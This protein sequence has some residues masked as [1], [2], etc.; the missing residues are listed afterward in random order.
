MNIITLI[1]TLYISIQNILSY[2]TGGTF[3]LGCGKP[4]LALPICENCR[5]LITK[6]KS[7]SFE[8]KE[9]CRQCGKILIAEDGLCS[10]CR[11]NTEIRSTLSYFPLHTYRLWK[12][13]LM[14]YWKSKD[15]RS[16]SLFFADLIYKAILQVSK[17]RNLQFD[18][19]V[20]VP[21]RPGKLKKKG[22]D[23][24]DELCRILHFKYKINIE[25]LLE[26]YDSH[27]Q[28]KL[29]KDQRKDK[30]GAE[31]GLKGD[32]KGTSKRVLILDDVI[33]T[34]STMEKCAVLLKKCGIREVYGMSLFIVD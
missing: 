28:K 1:E 13:D 6:I 24:I 17:E 25:H 18:S 29:S 11:E 22:W 4:C 15:V 19:I 12:K 20:P 34:G 30:N 10:Q 33:T 16:F 7:F 5:K 21:P 8:S 9:R 32:Y 23:Q 27:E 31:Y 2:V 26:R 3:C 14:Y